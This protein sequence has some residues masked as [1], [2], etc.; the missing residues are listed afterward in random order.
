[1]QLITQFGPP[2]LYYIVWINFSEINGRLYKQNF[3][4][5]KQNFKTSQLYKILSCSLETNNSVF[6][7]MQSRVT[8]FLFIRFIHL[9]SD[10]S[11]SI[12]MQYNYTTYLRNSL[13][14]YFTHTHMC[15]YKCVCV[16]VFT[17]IFFLISYF[18]YLNDETFICIIIFTLFSTEI[19]HNRKT[20]ENWRL[21]T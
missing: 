21:K 7:K 1:M 14:F 19:S 20:S 13:A 3:I 5:F 11:I 8:H 9:H 6:F 12:S 15:L 16:C 17:Y 4:L 2:S 10:L 18:L